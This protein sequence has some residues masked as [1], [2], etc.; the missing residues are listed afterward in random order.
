[1]VTIN[2]TKENSREMNFEI[3]LFEN[4]MNVSCVLFCDFSLIA[5]IFPQR[6]FLHHRSIHSVNFVHNFGVKFNMYISIEMRFNI[7]CIS[8]GVRLA[9]V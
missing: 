4:Q 6:C 2:A 7:L 9:R 5:L 8:I 1:M 3:S